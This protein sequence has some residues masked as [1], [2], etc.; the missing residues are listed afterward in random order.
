MWK[1][2]FITLTPQRRHSGQT[3]WINLGCFRGY[4]R[5]VQS[6]IQPYS[7]LT[8]PLK[9]FR[10]CCLVIMVGRLEDAVSQSLRR[11]P[12]WFHY[13]LKTGKIVTCV[14]WGGGEA[15]SISQAFSCPPPPEQRLFYIKSLF[16][17]L[18]Q[19]TFLSVKFSLMQTVSK[20]LWVHI[21]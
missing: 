4:F 20:L 13:P 16:L 15:C 19:I 9:L 1:F 8:G 3:G 10:H 5:K 7:I 21:F 12:F 18:I 11:A 14:C 2:F 6:A 17:G